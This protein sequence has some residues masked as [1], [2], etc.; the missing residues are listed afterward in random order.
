M[1]ILDGIVEKIGI[2][3]KMVKKAIDAI[4]FEEAFNK[5]PQA[6]IKKIEDKNKEIQKE[7]DND[8][9]NVLIVGETGVGKSTLINTIF[10]NDVAKVGTGRPITQ[11]IEAYRNEEERLCIYDTKGLE[12]KDSS[13]I[14]NIEDFIEAQEQK[15]I[16]EQ[17]HI[18]LFCIQE[19]TKR[20]QEAH[21]DLYNKLQSHYVPTILV[22]TKAQRD[23]DKNGEKFSDF[24]KKEFNISDDSIQR[25]RALPF[26][27]DTGKVLQNRQG[28]DDLIKKMYDKMDEG[29]RNAFGRKQRYD[30]KKRIESL[31]EKAL[32]LVDKYSV[33][34]GAVAGNPIPFS[35]IF[36]ILPAQIMMISHISMIYGLFKEDSRRENIKKI[37]IAFG[38]VCIIGFLARFVFGSALKLLPGF[39]SLAGGLINAAVAGAI[40]KAM[41]NVYVGYLSDN[42]DSILNFGFNIDDFVEFLKEHKDDIMK[43]IRSFAK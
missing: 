26:I 36:L 9:L 37:I 28:I 11:E 34:A 30:D 33:G 41:G 7:E 17:I 18:A 43:I 22:I 21:I 3:D 10:G 29:R 16:S 5:I 4:D 19:A 20:V 40:T 38:S 1:G 39:G 27:D 12:I 23:A 25:V 6:E 32:G 15:E 2:V 24:V 14:S 8:W 35:D 31:R 42:Y 13:T